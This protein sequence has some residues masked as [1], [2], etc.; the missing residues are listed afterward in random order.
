MRIQVTLGLETD[1]QAD[2][3]IKLALA[4]GRAIGP[5]REQPAPPRRLRPVAARRRHPSQEAE[6][7]IAGRWADEVF[8]YRP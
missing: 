7:A 6:A 8:G 1:E 4:A 3:I 2:G 5:A